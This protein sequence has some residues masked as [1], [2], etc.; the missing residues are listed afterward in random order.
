M[1]FMR[2]FYFYKVLPSPWGADFLFLWLFLY[3]LCC[4]SAH[5]P[6]CN[7]SQTN[8]FFV[9]REEHLQQIKDFF[10]KNDKIILALTGGPG[11]GKSQ[12]AKKYAH[13]YHKDYD[14]IW[15]IDA[16]QDI[17]GQIEKLALALNTLLPQKEH[18]IPS[19]L[20]KEALV[21][22]VKNT[23]KVKKIRYLLIFDNSET[24][25]RVD[26]YIPT[27]HHP[28][29]KHALLTSRNANIWIDKIEVGKFKREESL[30]MIKAAL[31]QEK[32]EDMVK[33]A[34]ALS[35]YPL[36]LFLALSFIKSHPTVTIDKYITMHFKNSLKKAGAPPG[37]LLDH[38]P[39]GALA[40]LDISLQYIGEES[41]DSLQ[42]LFL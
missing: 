3:P 29:H 13:I 34:E 19:K 31:P 22:T 40:T 28:S 6:V 11:F 15:W 21:D 14:F 7:L 35:D 16:Q 5:S 36:G 1:P 18:I 42:A 27:V 24:Y 25:E 8:V 30:R 41:K 2:D 20:S 17:P 26:Q 12:I 32:K 38:Y 37:A 39:K 23:L 10:K 33:L 9:G 4:F